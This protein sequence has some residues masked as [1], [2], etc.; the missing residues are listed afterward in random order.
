MKFYSALVLPVLL[1]VSESWTL[2]KEDERRLLAAEMAWL[3]R[4]RGNQTEEKE[5]ERENKR[6]T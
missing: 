6:R 4:I 2:R 3:R 5:L 1:Y